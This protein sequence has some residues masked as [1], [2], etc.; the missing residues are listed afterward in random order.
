MQLEEQFHVSDRTK[1]RQWMPWLSLFRSFRISIGPRALLLGIVAALLIDLGGQLIQQLPFAAGT[2]PSAGYFQPI[3]SVTPRAYAIP[4]QALAIRPIETLQVSASHSEVMVRPLWTVVASCQLL[5]GEQRS[6]SML[7][8][9]WSHLLWALIVW[10][11]FGVAISR[12]AAVRFAAD[13]SVGIR[14]SL[15]FSIEKLPAALAAPIL[16]LLGVGFLWLLCLGGGLVGRIPAVGPVI[17]GVMWWLPLLLATMMTLI[18]L[19]LAAGWPLMLSSIGTEDAD[20]FDA[21]SRAYSYLFSRPWYALFLMTLALLYGSL[22]LTF[23]ATVLQLL[24]PLAEWSIASG[25]GVEQTR[26]LLQLGGDNPGMATS[27]ARFWHKVASLGLVGFVV[28]YFWTA[29]TIIYF[30]LRKSVD[31]M[32]LETVSERVSNTAHALPVVGVAAAEQRE[33]NSTD[34]NADPAPETT[35]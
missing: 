1:L 12:M 32:P 17:V 35:D 14:P 2:N 22:L 4:P 7:A 9:V 34:E 6:W 3:T 29:T 15:R 20:S 24:M 23:V 27:A 13:K 28:S 33:A 30:L 21:F 8:T 18:L 19:G 25:M 11:L 10:G 26:E 16:P 31:G 5:F